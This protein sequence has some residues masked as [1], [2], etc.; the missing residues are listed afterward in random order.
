MLKIF[1]IEEIEAKTNP[2]AHLRNVN[3]ETKYTL[4]E[5]NSNYKEPTIEINK[6]ESTEKADKFNAAHYSTGAVAASFTSTVMVPKLVHEAAIKHEDEVRYDRVKKKGYVRFVTNLG[7]LNLEVYCNDVPMASE[8][9]IRHC[10]NGY[11]NGTK[12]FR[13]I[14]NFM[15]QGGDPTNTGTGGDSIWG[16]KFRDEF[17][18]NLTHTGRGVLSMANSG[19]NTNG[20]QL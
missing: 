2:Q 18:T 19:K 6:K 10:A 14:R 8:N 9:F 4:E 15:V 17:R 3:P 7:P 1:F 16:K 12:F 11:Y 20:S 5:L 13:S